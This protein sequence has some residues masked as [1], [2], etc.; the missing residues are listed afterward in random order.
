MDSLKLKD[1]E[2]KKDLQ[3]GLHWMTGFL[4]QKDFLMMMGL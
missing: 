4:M 1:L 2:N 3:I